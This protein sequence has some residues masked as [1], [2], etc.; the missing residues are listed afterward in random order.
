MMKRYSSVLWLMA[1]AFIGLAC[2]GNIDPEDDSGALD[3]PGEGV[4]TTSLS[5][6]Y[7][8]K[9]IAMQFTSVGCTNCP[10]LASALKD[11]DKNYPDA[12][13]PVAF[14]LDFGEYTD[15][16]TLPVNTK[17]YKALADGSALSLPMFALD[18]R[19]PSQHIVNEYSKIVS[20]MTLQSEKY[21][22]VCGVALE[23]SYDKV[24][25]SVEVKA[26]FRSD[27]YS[28][29]RYHIFLL[30]DGVEYFQAGSDV[31]AYVH[32]NVLRA[33]SGDNILGAK[34][35][36]GEPLEPGKEYEVVKKMTLAQE[37]NEDKIRVVVAMLGTDDEGKTFF[38]NNV[39][40]CAL[41]RSAGYCIEGETPPVESRFQRKVCVMEFT[42]TWCAQCP[43]GAT[44]LNYLVGKAYEGKAFALAFHN[45]DEYT[46]P[47]EQ[48]LYA[49]FKYGGYPA[50]VTDMCEDLTGLLNEGGCSPAIEKRLYDS[51]T[52]CGAAVSST[53]DAEKKTVTVDASMFSE[54]TMT[55][56]MAAY[57]IEDKVTGKQKQST[58]EVQEDY[59]HRHMVRKMLSSSVRGDSLGEVSVEKE[60]SKTYSFTVEDDWNVE[61]LSVAVLILDKDGH[62]NNMAICAA[63]G[64]KMD[65]EYLK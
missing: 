10:L 60:A 53:Y 45:N 61:N 4:D 14:H 57:V 47:Q 50:Y 25:R 16:M 30:E 65:Y 3:G 48:E 59:T 51:E 17:F 8:K 46:L 20:E 1:M 42:G 54:K 49:I 63:D 18:F 56:R 5:T 58:G 55:Y 35:N 38:S 62:V 23:S 13:V 39:N 32:D 15:P 43:A 31:E 12:I 34:L 40:W 44:T 37:W 21:P 29:Y 2:S 9:M 6:G 7:A 41:G 24:S 27:V 11:V 33:M 19:K 22:A 28:E 36:S 52:H 26:K 64:G